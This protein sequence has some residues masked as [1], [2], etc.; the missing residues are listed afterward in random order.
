MSAAPYASNLQL[1]TLA[2]M[3]SSNIFQGFGVHGVVTDNSDHKLS[4]S[5]RDSMLKASK[6]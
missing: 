3:V 5:W 1:A 2:A 4:F 6:Q